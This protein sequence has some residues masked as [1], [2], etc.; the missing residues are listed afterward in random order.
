M[1]LDNE[2][3]PE[4]DLEDTKALLIQEFSVAQ[5]RDST[6]G[7]AEE[8]ENLCT[9]DDTP[10]SEE[11]KIEYPFDVKPSMNLMLQFDQVLTQRLLG[12]HATWLI[13]TVLHS[14]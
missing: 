3:E 2:Q 4:K 7:D 5:D 8:G 6:G 9:S 12:Y 10:L 1:N 13:R 14:R 11:T